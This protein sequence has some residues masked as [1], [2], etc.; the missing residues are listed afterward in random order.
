MNVVVSCDHHFDRSPDGAI[1]AHGPLTHSFW[2][3]YRPAFE[4]VRL[5]AR[6]RDIPEAPAGEQPANGEGVE[7]ISVPDFTGPRQYLLRRRAI[8][9]AARGAI[10][11]G[12]AVMLRAPAVMGDCLMPELERTGRPYGIEVVTDPY[13]VFGSKAVRHPLRRFFRWSF[14]RAL[15]A[16]CAGACGAAYVTEHALQ[17]RYPPGPGAF[18]T[19]YSSIDLPGSAFADAPRTAPLPSPARL[20]LVGTLAQLY[21][22][23]DVLIEAVA[24]VVRGGLAVELTIVGGGQHRQELEARAVE[25]GLN[26]VVRFTGNLSQSGAV[27]SELDRAD[28]FTMPSRQEGLPRAMI[29][30]MARGLPAIGST[31]GGIPELLP[32][33]DLVPTDDAPA[34]AAK[35]REMLGDPA[36]MA[37]ASARNLAKARE[38]SQ[39]ILTPRRQALYAHVRARTEEWLGKQRKR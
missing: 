1:W 7:F 19:H 30:A 5:I 16:Q 9:A 11:N 38:Y 24:E 33:E 34:L 20:L 25:L 15:R 4:R 31:V 28:L 3:R 18:A 21:K 23:P 10:R 32:A 29:E 37:R 2:L 13:D 39:E 36:R 17:R 22:A 12:D 8:V 27:R 14:A 26:G 6:V 35:I